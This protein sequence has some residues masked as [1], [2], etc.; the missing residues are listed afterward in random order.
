MSD[1]PIETYI[2][3]PNRDYTDEPVSLE[4]TLS[5]TEWEFESGRQ[6]WVLIHRK[7]LSDEQRER[8]WKLLEEIE[9]L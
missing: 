3:L 8:L 1:T 9:D 7:P 4:E 6:T 5:D 2:T